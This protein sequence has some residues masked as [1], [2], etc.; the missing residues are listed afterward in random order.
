MGGE[1]RAEGS[2]SNVAPAVGDATEAGPRTAGTAMKLTC[3]LVLAWYVAV[4]AAAL[5]A[6]AARLRFDDVEAH[7][8]GYIMPNIPRKRD[9]KKFTI[10]DQIDIPEHQKTFNPAKID[11]AQF[12]KSDFGSASEAQREGAF[13]KKWMRYRIADPRVLKLP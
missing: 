4:G 8:H 3:A 10:E 13:E 11:M 6:S 2:A 12:T 1:T 7:G 9:R 5:Q